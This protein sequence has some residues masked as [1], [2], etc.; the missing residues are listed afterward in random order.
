MQLGACR[1]ASGFKLGWSRT[2]AVV[3]PPCTFSFQPE[4]LLPPRPQQRA[5]IILVVPF[6]GACFGQDPQRRTR[7]DVSALLWLLEDRLPMAVLGYDV[8]FK[9]NMAKP[10]LEFLRD[11]EHPL[12]EY[13]SS[14]QRLVDEC[15]GEGGVNAKLRNIMEGQKHLETEQLIRM[16]YDLFAR[17][18]DTTSNNL[19]RNFTKEW[20]KKRSYTTRD[21]SQRANV[22]AHLLA[23]MILSLVS[24]EGDDL[25]RRA[26]T[27]KAQDFWVC[28]ALFNRNTQTPFKFQSTKHGSAGYALFP[29]VNNKANFRAPDSPGDGGCCGMVDAAPFNAQHVT[30]RAHCPKKSVVVLPCAHAYCSDCQQREEYRTKGGKF[31]CPHCAAESR[32]NLTEKANLYKHTLSTQVITVESLEKHE[33]AKND[34]NS[35][36]DSG[37][38]AKGM[39][40]DIPDMETTKKRLHDA[41][42]PA[43]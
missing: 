27:T 8:V 13:F 15:F 10:M 43:E 16:S 14:S 34:D 1:Q 41:L 7:F 29:Q 21:L 25:P 30:T 32:K 24:A 12:Y 37:T 6:N 22:A 35:D 11:S 18:M 4:L 39:L 23:D 38:D 31:H 17:N 28:K 36:D 33:Q 42:G 3:I 26:S 20:S 40:K 5:E 19:Q 9:S 2:R